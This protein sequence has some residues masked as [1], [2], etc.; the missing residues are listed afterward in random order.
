MPKTRPPYPAEF[1]QQMVEL[2]AAGRTPAELSREF[3]CSAQTIANWVA[4][5]GVK[6]GVAHRALTSTISNAEREELA[7]LRREN[8]RLRMERDILAKATAWFAAKSDKTF[9]P[10]TSS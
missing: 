2:V 9:T 10:S 7:R 3:G 6:A 4:S 1:R 5:S 8:R